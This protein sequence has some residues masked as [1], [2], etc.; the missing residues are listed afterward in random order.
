[1]VS[2]APT[3]N[4]H[5]LQIDQAG[6]LGWRALLASGVEANLTM[7]MLVRSGSCLRTNLRA[8]GSS[9]KRVQLSLAGE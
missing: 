3:L 5:S 7:S 1:M 6:C 2:T 8:P 4:L 9:V